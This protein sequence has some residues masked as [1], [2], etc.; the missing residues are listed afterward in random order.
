MTGGYTVKLASLGEGPQFT[1]LGSDAVEGSSRPANLTVI[2][3]DF[4]I[5]VALEQTVQG[6]DISSVW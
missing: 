1:R 6:A 3:G 5:L 2:E 4:E